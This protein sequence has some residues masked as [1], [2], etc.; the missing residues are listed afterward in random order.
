MKYIRLMFYTLNYPAAF[1]NFNIYAKQ[2]LKDAWNKFSKI[3]S[4]LFT[5]ALVWLSGEMAAAS[6]FILNENSNVHVNPCKDTYIHRWHK[7][8]C[9]WNH[10]CKCMHLRY[11][12][13]P[14]S[15]IIMHSHVPQVLNIRPDWMKRCKKCKCE[16]LIQLISRC[17]TFNKHL[18]N[19]ICLTY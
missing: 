10:Q 13:F 7:D 1:W 2:L 17:Y 16:I 8:L 6:R 4:R 12:F 15:G 9:S 3:T 19:I 5:Q 18:F 14:W 11:L